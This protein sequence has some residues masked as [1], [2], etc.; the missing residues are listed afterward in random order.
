[1]GRLR[2]RK[3]REERRVEAE[4]RAVVR[5]DPLPPTP[6]S[7]RLS[8]YMERHVET[9]PA[10]DAPPMP[11]WARD[12]YW[13]LSPPKRDAYLRQVLLRIQRWVHGR[14]AG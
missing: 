5:A 1:M 6:H 2:R 8:K 3:R 12:R 10:E 4:R 7:E 14:H 9:A 11:L 13:F